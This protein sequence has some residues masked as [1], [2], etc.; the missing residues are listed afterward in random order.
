MMF[1]EGLTI[2]F[3]LTSKYLQIAVNPP[4]EIFTKSCTS[5]SESEI[6]GLSEK[7]MNFQV[8]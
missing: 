3:T 8:K 7:K 4:Q 6:D 1:T 5:T 2:K